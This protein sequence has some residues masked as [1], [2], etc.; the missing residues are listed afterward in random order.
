MRVKISVIAVASMFF[1]GCQGPS[2]GG[3]SSSLSSS[4]KDEF[5]NILNEDR[6]SSVCD[7][8]P[9][10]NQYKQTKDEK[11]LKKLLYRYSENLANSCIDIPAFKRALTARNS[12]AVYE[13]YKEHVSSSDIDAKL[14]SGASVDSILQA[15]APTTPQFNALINAYNSAASPTEQYK[16]KLNI[17][18]TKLFKDSGWSGTYI[19]VNVPE[20]KFRLYENGSKSLEFNVIT[21]KPSWPTPIFSSIMKYITVNPTWNVPDNIARKEEIP[22]IIRDKGYLRRHNMVVKRDYGLDSPTVNPSS[23]NWKEYLKPEWAHK[24]LPYKIVEKASNRNALGVVK[25]I[26]PNRHSVYMHDTPNKRLFSRAVRAFSHG[27]IRLQKPLKLLGHISTFYTKQNFEE[28]GSILKAK[29]TKYINLKQ[30][31]PVNIVYLTKYVDGGMLINGV[32][33]YGYDKI[34]KLK[35]PTTMVAKSTKK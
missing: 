11:I 5:I 24:D 14:K 2:L 26:F 3:G 34:T 32:D 28:V 21:G 17:E 25:F 33:I 1:V 35:I 30:K 20:F 6:Y 9:M 22:K 18:R 12:K 7:L 31:I 29:K 27:C 13:I 16:I 15:Y 19:V 8:Q 23:V 10:I 4:Q